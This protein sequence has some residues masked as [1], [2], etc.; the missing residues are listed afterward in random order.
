MEQGAFPAQSGAEKQP[1]GVGFGGHRLLPPAQK[2]RG[3]ADIRVT[4]PP[5][6]RR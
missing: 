6:R 5:V 2:G 1:V 3:D 4:A